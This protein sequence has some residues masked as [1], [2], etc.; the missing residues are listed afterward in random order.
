MLNT[1]ISTANSL[2]HGEASNL[3]LTIADARKLTDKSPAI[4]AAM[5]PV[6][7]RS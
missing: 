3:G 6:E 5:P 4:D 7:I 1:S 2:I